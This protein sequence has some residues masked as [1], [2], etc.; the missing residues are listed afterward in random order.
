MTTTYEKKYKKYIRK[1][2]RLPP[3]VIMEELYHMKFTWYQKIYMW[4]LW[5]KERHNARKQYV[6]W[7]G[8]TVRRL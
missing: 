7:D 4:I 1:Y 2:N 8:K 6:F 5:K 3:Y